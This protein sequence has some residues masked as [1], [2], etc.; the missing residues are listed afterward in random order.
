MKAQILRS[1]IPTQPCCLPS[2]VSHIDSESCR[3]PCHPTVTHLA[4]QDRGSLLCFPYQELDGL[5]HWLATVSASAPHGC[6]QA[7]GSGPLAPCWPMVPVSSCLCSTMNSCCSTL[8][9]HFFFTKIKNQAHNQAQSSPDL[10]WE[11]LLR[12]EA[13]QAAFQRLIAFSACISIYFFPQHWNPWVLGS[14]RKEGALKQEDKESRERTKKE[15]KM[16]MFL[17]FCSKAQFSLYLFP[18]VMENKNCKY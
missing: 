11:A 8:N 15:Q 5:P 13:R 18:C 14:L 4:W 9:F 10:R 12:T 3:F 16:K 1:Q 7:A 2:L 6:Q 17:S